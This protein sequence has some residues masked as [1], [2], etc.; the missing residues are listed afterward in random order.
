MRNASKINATV[1]TLFLFFF[2]QCKECDVV[3]VSEVGLG[4]HLKNNKDN[5]CGTWARNARK[6]KKIEE[7]ENRLA[8]INKAKLKDLEMPKKLSGNKPHPKGKPMT[9][10][11]KQDI[12]KLYDANNEENKDWKKVSYK[13]IIF[14]QLCGHFVSIHV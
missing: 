10:E 9:K 5:A 4:R 12:M 3:L 6:Q 14:F 8:A 7:Q 1:F 13:V 11:E 2:R